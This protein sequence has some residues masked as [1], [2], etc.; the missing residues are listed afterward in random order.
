[1]LDRYWQAYKVI[2]T[3]RVRVYIDMSTRELLGDKIYDAFE[4]KYITEVSAEVS[5]Q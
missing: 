1:M 4:Y 3:Y 5:C 2:V